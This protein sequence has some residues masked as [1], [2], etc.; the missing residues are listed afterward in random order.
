MLRS[1]EGQSPSEMRQSARSV[2]P[3]LSL[4]SESPDRDRHRR[5]RGAC[6]SFLDPVPPGSKVT[7]YTQHKQMAGSRR[8]GRPCASRDRQCVV[9]D[10]VPQQRPPN[11]TEATNT[12][13]PPT[14]TTCEGQRADRCEHYEA[15][16]HFAI[17]RGDPRLFPQRTSKHHRQQSAAMPGGRNCLEG[18][19]TQWQ[20]TRPGKDA[21]RP[22]PHLIRSTAPRR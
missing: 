1:D 2:D 21:A 12:R 8:D 7:G 19:M 6:V 16:Q 14:R 13:Q 18:L 9:L 11:L 15:H 5:T 3:S 10:L 20:R 22:R 4:L 17:D